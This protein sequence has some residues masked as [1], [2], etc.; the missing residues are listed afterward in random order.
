MSLVPFNKEVGVVVIE[1]IGGT[2]KKHL[3][4]I[5]ENIGHSFVE[6]SVSLLSSLTF[7]DTVRTMNEPEY[8]ESLTLLEDFRLI[9]T[10]RYQAAFLID[11]LPM[12]CNN[13]ISLEEHLSSFNDI[14]GE[15]VVSDVNIL[16]ND[17]VIITKIINN[18]E[19]TDE[20]ITD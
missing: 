11:V 20:Y 3:L 14:N 7:I 4:D 5:H 6:I 16:S 19:Y 9:E 18:E 2:F 13:S 15:F 17:V 12:Q 10:L 8:I 1:G